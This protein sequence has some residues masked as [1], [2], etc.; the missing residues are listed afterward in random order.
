MELGLQTEDRHQPILQEQ[1]GNCTSLNPPKQESQVNF[2]AVLLT[3]QNKFQG[4]N[5]LFFLYPFQK[6][7]LT[8]KPKAECPSQ[9]H[10][11]SEHL[12][13]QQ[14]WVNSATWR[15]A[16]GE[17]CQPRSLATKLP[18]LHSLGSGG[19]LLHFQKCSFSFQYSQF[20]DALLSQLYSTLEMQIGAGVVKASV[21]FSSMSVIRYLIYNRK[22]LMNQCYRSLLT[23]QM[24]RS[25][26]MTKFLCL[27][28]CFSSVHLSYLFQ[29]WLKKKKSKVFKS[30]LL[31]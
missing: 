4:L 12:T 19:Q 31:F 22:Q 21:T 24:S 27:L 5:Q 2:K 15:P 10:L 3:K 20:P 7:R 16:M 8:L 6:Q 17:L 25:W 23:L 26:E 30:A 9:K 13:T 14:S 28:Y 29:T 11:P 18:H 1:W